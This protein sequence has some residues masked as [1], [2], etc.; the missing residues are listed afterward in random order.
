MTVGIYVHR[1]LSIILVMFAFE[2]VRYWRFQI[3]CNVNRLDS[4]V[5]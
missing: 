4:D 5:H 2:G 3:Y 1:L